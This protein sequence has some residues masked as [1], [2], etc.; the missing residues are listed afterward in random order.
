MINIKA[1]AFVSGA[2]FIL[3]LVIGLLSGAGIFAL[4]R[5]LILGAVFFLISGGVY[6]LIVKFLPELLNFSPDQPVPEVRAG[7]GALVDIS[8]GEEEPEA[9]LGET[10]E[11]SGGPGYLLQENAGI[12]QNDNI[13]YTNQ[14]RLDDEVPVG[15]SSVEDGV[16]RS[17]SMDRLSG[18][19]PPLPVSRGHQPAV[20]GNFFDSVDELPD[21]DTLA[22]AFASSDAS[23][24]G[25]V[26]RILSMDVSQG[27]GGAKPG[28]G[29][30]HD[31]STHDMA[32]A[33]QTILKQD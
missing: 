16:G 25:S 13:G 3:S 21:M 17:L 29:L 2:A 24:G 31:Y 23:E 7:P 27:K 1:S 12:D 14:G 32:A 33:I 11:S 8:L 30:E 9:V 19:S 10:P 26:D 18:E 15:E 6:W 22:S 20:P 5:A 4:V 28:K